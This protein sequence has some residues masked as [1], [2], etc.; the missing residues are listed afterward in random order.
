VTVSPGSISSTGSRS[1]PNSQM[2]WSRV[3]R[4]TRRQYGPCASQS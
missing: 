2:T 1:G 3:I 4:C